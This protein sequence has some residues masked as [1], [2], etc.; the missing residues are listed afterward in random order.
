MDIKKFKEVVDLLRDKSKQEVLDYLKSNN[1]FTSDEKN[2]IW[3]YLFPRPILDRES[4]SRIQENRKRLGNDGTGWREP[5][6]SETGIFLELLKTSQYG[7]FMWHLLHSFTNPENIYPVDGDIKTTC[8]LCGKPIYQYRV[9]KQKCQKYPETGESEKKE[10]LS[11]SSK[12]SNIELCLDCLI[13]LQNLNEWLK[14][15]INPGYLDRYQNS[16]ETDK[17][18]LNKK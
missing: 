11:F 1:T 15:L 16:Y 6:D 9:W 2:I 3:I 17:K 5:N 7:N 13:Q 18:P 14:V 12:Q 8:C 4:P 10:F